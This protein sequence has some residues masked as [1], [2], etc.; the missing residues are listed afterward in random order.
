[1]QMQ[2]GLE[3]GIGLVHRV[4]VAKENAWRDIWAK[5]E[6]ESRRPSYHAIGGLFLR[7]IYKPKRFV[8]VATLL[9]R[10]AVRVGERQENFFS[11]LFPLRW[12]VS[13]DTA[14][15]Q[16]WGGLAASILLHAYS[17]SDLM[18]VHHFPDYF[19]RSQLLLQVGGERRLFVEKLTAGLQISWDL[20]AAW[21]RVLF[22]E[23][24]TLARHFTAG[25]YL[26]YA[27]WSWQ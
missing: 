3:G 13:I 27:G 10:Y 11:I 20:T 5:R 25:I 7:H 12:G 23:H 18:S 21:D 19:S 15:T 22:Q 4:P 24:R 1:M 8:E 2:I 16:I 26:R 9:R 6:C 17:R 14:L